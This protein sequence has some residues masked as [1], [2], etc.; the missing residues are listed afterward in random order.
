LWKS[1]RAFLLGFSML[2]L[3]GVGVLVNIALWRPIGVL[4]F[5]CMA[6]LGVIVLALYK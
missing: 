2:V 1:K 6:C 5:A 4:L 3:G